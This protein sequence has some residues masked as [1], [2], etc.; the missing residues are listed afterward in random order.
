MH[1]GGEAFGK[2]LQSARELMSALKAEWSKMETFCI[3]HY[4]S[5]ERVK[6]MLVLQFANIALGSAWDNH[7]ASNV[8]ITFKEPF[9]TEGRGLEYSH[10]GVACFLLG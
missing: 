5:K 2:D 6:N 3:D 8:Q 1:C 7:P 4:P 10:Y 9:G